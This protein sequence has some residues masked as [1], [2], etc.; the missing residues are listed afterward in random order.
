MS[1]DQEAVHITTAKSAS[2][3]DVLKGMHYE[4]DFY[5]REY[6]WG[7]EQVRDL[8]ED[9]TSRFLKGYKPKDTPE[10]TAEYPEYFLGSLILTG[11]TKHFI[12]DGQQRLTTLSLIFLC[13]YKNAS[14]SG[15]RDY[16]YSDNRGHK[17]YNI[18]NIGRGK[19]MNTI[20]EGKNHS[21]KSKESN[22]V[23]SYTLICDFFNELIS[24]ERFS[25][26][27]I[28]CFYYWLSENVNLI[29]IE[30]VDNNDAYEIFES[31]NDRG[32]PLT[33]SE[34]LKGYLLS[35]IDRNKDREQYERKWDRISNKFTNKVSGDGK[36]SANTDFDRFIVDLFRAKWAQESSRVGRD[37]DWSQIGR[38]YHR[39]LKA[40]RK[41]D[42]VKLDSDESIKKLIDDIDW[43][44]SLHEKLVRSVDEGYICSDL[45]II[46]QWGVP[47]V[48]IPFYALMNP[49]DDEADE[50][51][52]I[53]AISKF[54]SIKNALQ[55]WNNVNYAD[56][57]NSSHWVVKL[58]K[59]SRAKEDI[60]DIDVLV[61]FLMTRLKNM[62]KQSVAFNP[63][64]TPRTSRGKARVRMLNFISAETAFVEAAATFDVDDID[65][66][67]EFARALMTKYKP[68][69]DVEH[70]LAKDFSVN[71]GLF[72]SQDDLD[73]VR[74]N[75]GNLGILK[76]GDNR[77]L[78]DES[79]LVKRDKYAQYNNYL[80]AILSPT[81]YDDSGQN[82][83]NHSKLKSFIKKYPQLRRFFHP[84]DRFD[85]LQISKR[86]VMFSELAKI[87]WDVDK[88]LDFC[89]VDTYEE[90]HEL[91]GN[92][93]DDLGD[94][95]DDIIYQSPKAED[96]MVFQ[97]IFS[98]AQEETAPKK[99]EK[100]DR[101]VCEI[102]PE[103]K[104][105]AEVSGVFPEKTMVMITKV[106]NGPYISNFNADSNVV[107]R[108]RY[109]SFV[110]KMARNGKYDRMNRM[111][112]WR[113][114]SSPVTLQ[115]ATE[116]LYGGILADGAILEDMWR[117]C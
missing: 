72:Q 53:R 34:M 48:F 6:S 115:Y 33:N 7:E 56:D 12:V 22:V 46:V 13:L 112:S 29:I 77:S 110:N 81:M 50:N 17:E 75:I 61:D 59:S 114:K 57:G 65:F 10:R 85:A 24:S 60:D 109:E 86:G 100:G 2:V 94:N 74:D 89:S 84:V 95:E 92:E 3:K 58:L 25:T 88:M 9:L 73:L 79:Y 23:K 36:N 5:Q 62:T 106:E 117:L 28:L 96:Q 93:D 31:M 68:Q 19:V 18:G 14:I 37:S 30:T 39:W 71:P 113:G 8:L 41:E 43:Y 21:S 49:S 26:D 42:Q 103:R 15:A 51:E 99:F 44:S 102:E 87:I 47:H 104:M 45:S 64:V 38:H 52:R 78:S 80:L 54:L 67:G 35:Q 16:V 76:K 111:Y 101:I 55:I 97:P 27:A 98:D 91:C 105:I 40:N 82:L 66:D 32:K 11:G 108:K 116:I 107:Y 63:S 20:L 4:L 83:K 1:N 70:I 69:S 90:L